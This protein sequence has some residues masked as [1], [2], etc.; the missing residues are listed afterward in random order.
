[1]IEI[2]KD[3]R[4][5]VIGAGPI[6][7][8][9]LISVKLKGAKVWAADILEGRLEMARQYGADGT[10]NTK[11]KKFTEAAAEIT[12]GDGFDVCIEA[13]GLPETFLAAIDCAAFAVNIILIGNGK[14]ETTF[15]HSVLL[16]KELKV[17]GSRNS[18]EKDFRSL[19]Q[20][21]AKDRIDIMRMVSAIYPIERADE[22]FKALASNNG[23]LTKILIEVG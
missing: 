10:I 14:K 22:A 17:F 13:C 9:A 18:L 11:N 23:S 15:L 20:T 3:D 8:F 7:L 12:N 19:I 21:V 6:G 4:V 5:L 1:L 2:K 16:K